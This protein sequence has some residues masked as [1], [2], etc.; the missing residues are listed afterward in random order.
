MHS[1]HLWSRIIRF[2][3]VLILPISLSGCVPVAVALWEITSGSDV[4][5]RSKDIAAVH[6]MLVALDYKNISI[7]TPERRELKIATF[8]TDKVKH[9]EV[10]FT[11]DA[12]KQIKLA[13]RQSGDKKF[14][15]VARSQVDLLSS[16]IL[17][18]F[19]KDKVKE[20]IFAKTHSAD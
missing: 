20:Q 19:G 16:S 1:H 10:I 12:E 8:L 14:T 6:T 3:I 18:V 9:I 15:I 2:V 7:D 13:L 5:S 11:W 17:A 4:A